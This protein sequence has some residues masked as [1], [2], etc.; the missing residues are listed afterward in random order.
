M[1]ETLNLM[2]KGD[3]YQENYDDIIQLCIRCSQGSTRIR[4]TWRDTTTKNNKA[5]SGNIT[6][7]EID[8]IF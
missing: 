8:N 1:N 5:A 6:W 2:G 3:I 4:P 7:T